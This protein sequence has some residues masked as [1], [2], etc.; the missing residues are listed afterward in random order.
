VVALA[1]IQAS[2]QVV[3]LAGIQA[4]VQAGIQGSILA[5]DLNGF[6]TAKTPKRGCFTVYLCMS[7]CRF[8]YF[9]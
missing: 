2:I 9:S 6:F 1:G 4:S 5:S 3:A 8:V 7:T